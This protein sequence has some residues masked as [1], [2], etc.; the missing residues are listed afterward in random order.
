[1]RKM[2]KRIMKQLIRS[3]LIVGHVFVGVLTELSEFWRRT[4][5]IANIREQLDAIKVS[6][7][8]S[9]AEIL[10]T[11]VSMASLIPLMYFGISTLEFFRSLPYGIGYIAYS[12]LM[13]AFVSAVSLSL[14]GAGFVAHVNK[15]VPNNCKR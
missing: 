6:I 12:V 3:L 9:K 15:R 8:N 10:L 2:R 11:G 5:S 7:C 4:I 13:T 1:M 14:L